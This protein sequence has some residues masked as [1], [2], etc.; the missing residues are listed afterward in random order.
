MHLIRNA[1]MGTQI[2]FEAPCI[3]NTWFFWCC[4]IE[5]SPTTPLFSYKTQ[6]LNHLSNHLW[7]GMGEVKLW[8]RHPWPEHFPG[9]R[10]F[11]PLR[12]NLPFLSGENRL[13]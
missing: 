4:E 8:C 10:P 1:K 9:S 2:Q 12:L 13:F 11:D 6:L 7:K 5:G 3:S